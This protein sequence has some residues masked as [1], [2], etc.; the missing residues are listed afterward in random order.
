MASVLHPALPDFKDSAVDDFWFA[1]G[2]ANQ[3]AFP[4]ADITTTGWTVT[5]LWSKLDEQFADDSD[6]VT[7]VA[8]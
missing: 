8:S 2:A 7:G 4:V 3:F 5:P 1:G 6:L